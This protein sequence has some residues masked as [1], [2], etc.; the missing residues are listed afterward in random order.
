MLTPKEEMSLSKKKQKLKQKQTHNSKTAARKAQ[1]RSRQA[2]TEGLVSSRESLG[3]VH[4]Q[5]EG[6]G[7]CS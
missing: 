3:S 4:H 7:F 5:C 2:S 1:L 6:K